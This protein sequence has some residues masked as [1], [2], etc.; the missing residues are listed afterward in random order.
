[1]PDVRIQDLARV[2]S[3]EDGDYLVVGSG[4]D[5]YKTTVG[6]LKAAISPSLLYKRITVPVI[7]QASNDNVYGYS[8]VGVS[9]EAV[10]GV[11]GDAEMNFRN[12]YVNITPESLGIVGATVDET[13]AF[14]G[15][16]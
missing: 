16:E 14:L 1:M 9:I 12:G 3:L 4:N 15:I 8:G 7:Y 11:K 6:D 5:T 2:N 10:T 13:K